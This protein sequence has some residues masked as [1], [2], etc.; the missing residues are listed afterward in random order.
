MLGRAQLTSLLCLRSRHMK[1]PEE[2][3]ANELHRELTRRFHATATVVS[4][5]GAGVHW[6]CTASRGNSQCSIACFTSLGTEYYTD[7]K[8]D[9]A[10][11]ATSRIPSRNQTIDAVADWLDGCELA[12]IHERYSFVD[13]T[14]RTLSRLRDEVM[15][16]APELR[17]SA[18]FSLD[19]QMADIYYLRVKADDR[20][21]ELSFYGKN[22]LPDAKFAWDDCQLFQYQPDDNSRLA[23]VLKRWICDRCQPSAMRNEFSW[24]QIGELADYYEGG[25]PVE[26][27]F[28]QSWD[29]ME[30]FYDDM[31]CPF[32]S[33]VKGFMGEMRSKG[34]HK[35]L[36]AGQSLWSLIL[37]RSRRHGLRHEQPCLQF[38]FHDYGMDVF[39]CITH[40]NNDN[41]VTFN[42][43]KLLPQIERWL[44]QLQAT[45][46][47]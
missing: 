44:Q 19:H 16:F 39:N 23:A 3:V 29:W 8:R 20:S 41:K 12:E 42:E 37:S 33:Q 38:W 30:Q 43:I 35:T 34:F 14:K 25:K 15:A 13:N 7:F 46:I 36:R 32:A 2:D 31:D 6:H 11:I 40:A 5:E 1:Y 10:G 26:G 4:I 21:C 47:D 18:H 17:H 28:I 22:E 45:A 24:L 9:G 27:E